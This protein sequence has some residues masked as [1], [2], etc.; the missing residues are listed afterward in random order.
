MGYFLQNSD[1]TFEI[2]GTF[3]CVPCSDKEEAKDT[4]GKGL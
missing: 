3:V 1:V 2:I 4:F